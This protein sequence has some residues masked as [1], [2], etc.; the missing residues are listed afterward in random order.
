MTSLHLQPTLTRAIT[1]QKYDASLGIQSSEAR[2]IAAL[3]LSE[4]EERQNIELTQK[5][6]KL[7]DITSKLQESG[8]AI[9]ESSDILVELGNAKTRQRKADLAALKNKKKL[10]DNACIGDRDA[11]DQLEKLDNDLYLLAHYRFGKSCF[12]DLARNGSQLEE[13]LSASKNILKDDFLKSLG[14][15]SEDQKYSHIHRFLEFNSD[16]VAEFSPDNNDIQKADL[17]D[18]LPKRNNQLETLNL[19][20][21]LELYIRYSQSIE[22]RS[23]ESET[24]KNNNRL[25]IA[26]VL[27]L[28]KYVLPGDNRTITFSD[29]EKIEVLEEDIFIKL[30][31]SPDFEKIME[32]V[33]ELSANLSKAGLIKKVPSYKYLGLGRFLV[34]DRLDAE[35]GYDDLSKGMSVGVKGVRLD[36]KLKNLDKVD[37]FIVSFLRNEEGLKVADLPQIYDIEEIKESAFFQVHAVSN[38]EEKRLQHI[39]EYNELLQQSN[40]ADNNYVD[41]LNKLYKALNLCEEDVKVLESKVSKLDLEIKRL[42]EIKDEE[43]SEISKLRDLDFFKNEVVYN[44]FQVLFEDRVGLIPLM[45]TILCDLKFQKLNFLEFDLVEKYIFGSIKTL[46]K[47]APK[48]AFE[49]KKHFSVLKVVYIGQS[50]GSFNSDALELVEVSQ[51]FKLQDRV[52]TQLVHE[53]QISQ[54]IQIVDIASELSKSARDDYYTQFRLER[55]IK[56]LNNQVDSQAFFDFQTRSQV[57]ELGVVQPLDTIQK[58][59]QIAEIEGEIND[60]NLRIIQIGALLVNPE[61][62]VNANKTS[63]ARSEALNEENELNK[64]LASLATSGVGSDLDDCL[65]PMREI[66]F[67][68]KKEI[69]NRDVAGILSEVKTIRASLSKLQKGPRGFPFREKERLEREIVALKKELSGLFRVDKRHITA[70]DKLT[71]LEAEYKRLELEQKDLDQD[72]VKMNK[73][74]AKEDQL[75]RNIPDIRVLLEEKEQLFVLK[76]ELKEQLKVIKNGLE[77]KKKESL[78]QIDLWHEIFDREKAVV[79]AFVNGLELNP[80]DSGYNSSEED[81]SLETYKTSVI[82]CCRKVLSDKKNLD[83]KEKNVSVDPESIFPI[84]FHK[85][86]QLNAFK[87]FKDN[88]YASLMQ[89]AND[90]FSSSL[91]KEH[92]VYKAQNEITELETKLREVSEPIDKLAKEYNVTI[93]KKNALYVDQTLTDVIASVNNQISSLEFTIEHFTDS[94]AVKRILQK[95]I[96]YLNFEKQD[97]IRDQ[98]V[99]STDKETYITKREFNERQVFLDRLNFERDKVEEQMRSEVIVTAMDERSILISQIDQ[100][101]ADLQVKREKIKVRA[102]ELTFRVFGYNFRYYEVKKEK[103]SKIRLTK[104]KAQ[105]KKRG[106]TQFSL[107][108]FPQLLVEGTDFQRESGVF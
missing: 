87:L 71:K 46:E 6:K 26:K 104:V 75:L 34:E 19:F 4:N 93:E 48:L 29:L 36:F 61:R 47:V 14:F 51:R 62:I 54:S 38:C 15:H 102:L 82:A 101:K 55:K 43:I 40:R 9:A 99:K 68:A 84:A 45:S 86:E 44:L 72:E 89:S 90:Y 5:S 74:L 31:S 24:I 27:G 39:D 1:A 85:K 13:K 59:A 10:F 79:N 63:K 76:A 30:S 32:L 20:V 60:V 23:D 97:L 58:K 8:I 11:L 88:E 73:L 81:S 2:V 21:R 17:I 41:W 64:S 70:T 91:E 56:W 25:E 33:E 96:R 16:F 95:E 49:L 105:N 83:L 106:E 94:D 7:L 98:K 52:Y 50:V 69:E 12:D 35:E 18:Q 37:Q 77:N 107:V 103:N 57:E 22:S 80:F 78:T 66:Q 108:G 53:Y 3:H 28:F 100:K 65:S 67:K 92:N 42:D